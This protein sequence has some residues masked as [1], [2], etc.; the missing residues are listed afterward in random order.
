MSQRLA[1]HAPVWSGIEVF[2]DLLPIERQENIALLIG[3]ASE[4]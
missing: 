1:C 2:R 3:R 4:L